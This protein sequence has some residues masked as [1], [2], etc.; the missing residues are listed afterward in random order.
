MYQSDFIC[1]YKLMDNDIDQEELYRIQLLQAF[2]LNDWDHDKI[3]STILELYDM[4]YLTD[5]Y[6]D[7][8]VKARKNAN[9]VEILNTLS[10]HDSEIK[11]CDDDIIF[12]LLFQFDFFDFNHRCISDFL[13]TKTISPVNYNNLL[14]AISPTN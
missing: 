13:R 8:L 9:V 5:E 10:L 2:D 14:F 4:L 1:T 7:L 12:Q 3:N 11:N 6:K